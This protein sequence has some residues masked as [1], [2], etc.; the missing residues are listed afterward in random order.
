[1]HFWSLLLQN[2]HICLQ[3]QRQKLRFNINFSY[4]G[5]QNW[6]ALPPQL[7]SRVQEEVRIHAQ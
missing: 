2:G 5:T 7:Y 4:F 6:G 1:M 3:V